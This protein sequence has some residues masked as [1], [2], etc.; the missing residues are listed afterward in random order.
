MTVQR[1]IAESEPHQ[2]EI[3][4]ILRSWIFDVGSH[5][6]EKISNDIPYFE[7]YGNFCYLNP[8]QGG[9]DLGFVHGNILSNEQHLLE[10]KGRK[11]VKSATF[12]SVAELE[13]HEEEVR[14]LLNEAAI[15][16]EYHFKRKKKK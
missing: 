11:L 3:M 13:E 8:V 5:V 14:H 2:R 1:F 9:V 4:T 7:Y 10:S 6:K 15:L 16:N 12:Y